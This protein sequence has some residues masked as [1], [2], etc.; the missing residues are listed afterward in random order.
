M[1]A[2]CS[3]DG[4]DGDDS[5]DDSNDNESS[6]N[7]SVAST[8]DESAD[9]EESSIISNY[10]IDGTDLSVELMEESLSQVEQI[11][12]ETPSGQ[13]TTEVA[14]TIMEYSIDILRDRAG[15]WFIDVLD[16]NEEVIETVELETTFSASVDEI[17]TL[18]QLGVTG[19]SPDFEDVNFQLT[20][21]NTGDVPVEPLEI[22]M[23]VPDFDYRVGTIESGSSMETYEEA[24]LGGVVDRDGK[25]VI[26]SGSDNTYRSSYGDATST[27]LIFE[28]DRAN[29]IVGQSFQGEVVIR[30]QAER[31]DTIVPITIEMGDEVATDS[32]YTR[33]AFLRGTVI[34][35]R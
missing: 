16:A 9:E 19:E 28:G 33:N 25:I 26:P 10:G 18:A 5:S 1:I 35:K 34:S 32:D 22:Q 30:Y 27:L 29:E 15:T 4:S 20:I 6:S 17:G 3:G 8:D 31:E 11:R 7:S 24:N 21:M 2:G 23:V 12:V 14:E 13:K